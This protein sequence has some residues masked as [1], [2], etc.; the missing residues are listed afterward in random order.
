MELGWIFLLIIIV[1]GVV[2]IVKITK[3][4]ESSPEDSE[5]YDGPRRH[6]D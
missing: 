2:V 3:L 4:G 1:V 5:T 6:S